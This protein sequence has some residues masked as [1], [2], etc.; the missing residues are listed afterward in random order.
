MRRVVLFSVLGL[1][2]TGCVLYAIFAPNVTI[3]VDNGSQEPVNV[4]MDGAEKLVVAPGQADSF[5]CRSGAHQFVVKRGDKTVFEETK[6]V[7]SR[8]NAGRGKYLI[9]PEATNR[10]RTKEMQYGMSIPSFQ[11]YQDEEDRIGL[12]VGNLNLV[13]P[14][15]WIDVKPDYVL[16]PAPSSV[17][18]KTYSSRTVLVRVSSADADLILTTLTRWNRERDEALAPGDVTEK[19]GKFE[20]QKESR[21]DEY[22]RIAEAAERIAKAPD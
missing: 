18:G 20:K 1:A 10:Y 3:Y 17:Q 12:L 6:T 15:A 13:P 11:T 16:E 2:A 19:M 14:S 7:K 5:S 8:G 22:S 9:N 21:K 4:F